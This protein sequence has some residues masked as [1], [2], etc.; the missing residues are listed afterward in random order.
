[1]IMTFDVLSTGSC[2]HVYFLWFLRMTALV[3]AIVL[4]LLLL[5][6]LTYLVPEIV[7]MFV[8]YGSYVKQR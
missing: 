8:L 1:M 2:L 7:C 6:R 4:C 3:T 5:G